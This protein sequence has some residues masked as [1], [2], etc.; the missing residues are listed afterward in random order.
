MPMDKLVDYLIKLMRK[1]RSMDRAAWA[2]ELR[3]FA[4][5]TKK[6]G[7]KLVDYI[8]EL[9]R[10][11]RSMDRAAWARELREIAYHTKKQL[12]SQIPGVSAI[13]GILVGFWVASTFTNSPVKGVL[14]S[15]GIMKGGTHVVSNT[16]YK[17]LSVFLPLFATAL[18]AYAVQKSMKNYREK[19]MERDKAFVAQLGEKVRADLRQKLSILEM[20]KEAG[21]LSESECDTKIAN[22]YQSYSRN[23]L[24]S[25]EDILFKS[26]KG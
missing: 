21:L 25:L 7:D 18:T 9:I 2:R 10:K 14:S 20:A 6:Q 26:L 11:I 16:T 4:Y 24:S 1:I 23:D 17:F 19:R 8:I 3:K 13:A 22:L 5:Y 15:L 12:F